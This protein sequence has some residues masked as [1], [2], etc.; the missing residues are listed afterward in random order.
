MVL[1]PLNATDGAA[2]LRI[3][4][5]WNVA[6]MLRMAA[7]PPDAEEVSAWIANAELEWARGTASRF[8]VIKDRT[9]IGCADVDEI[10]DGWGEL[11]YWLDEAFWG[12]G[13]ASEVG[14]AVRDF[15]FQTLKL[16]GLKS[17]HAADNPASGRVLQKLGFNHIGDE[18]RWSMPRSAEIE[19]RLYRLERPLA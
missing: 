7:Y 4:A 18:R 19:Q 16:E 8:A 11:G 2:L 17:G 3:R 1:R 15:A 13:L 10:H 9:V 12:D 5:N 6:R 14:A